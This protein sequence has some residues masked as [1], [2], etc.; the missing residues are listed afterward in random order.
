MTMTSAVC[1]CFLLS[2]SKYSTPVIF[3]DASMIRLPTIQLVRNSQFPVERAAGITVLCVPHLAL[4]GHAKPQQV[5][6]LTHAGRPPYGTEFRSIGMGN[7]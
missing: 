3:P 4:M 6:L 5:R 7:G 2:L 1:S